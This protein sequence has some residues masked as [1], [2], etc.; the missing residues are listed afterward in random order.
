MENSVDGGAYEIALADTGA[1]G[2]QRP[3]HF[4]VAV[5]TA[6]SRAGPS[7]TFNWPTPASA[8][9]QQL[10]CQHAC[11]V[12]HESAC[13]AEAVVRPDRC[14]AFRQR[15]GLVQVPVA[16]CLGPAEICRMFPAQVTFIGSSRGGHIFLQCFVHRARRGCGKQAGHI[17]FRISIRHVWQ[18]CFKPRY[19]A[20]SKYFI[21]YLCAVA[22]GSHAPVSVLTWTVADF[23][24]P[25]RL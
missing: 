11:C 15:P 25:G 4:K 19:S 9:D 22:A 16:C 3:G 20:Q 12:R 5:P 13:V 1:P 2:D 14:A 24:N 8:P 21:G 7:L 18:G 23:A 17:A 6:S 10:R